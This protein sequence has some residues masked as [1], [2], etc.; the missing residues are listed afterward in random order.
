MTLVVN[1]TNMQVFDYLRMDETIEDLLLRAQ[2][3]SAN[4]AKVWESH[5]KN[6]PDNSD[7]YLRMLE[8]ERASNFKVMSQDEYFMAER[9]F[10]VSKPLM[11][12]TEERF[13]EMLNVLPP[14]YWTTISGVEMFCMSEM[15]TSSYTTQYAKAGDKYYSKMVDVNDRTTWIHNFLFADTAKVVASKPIHAGMTIKVYQLPWAT[16]ADSSED[17]IIVGVGDGDPTRCDLIAS[18]GEGLCAKIPEGDWAFC[19]NGMVFALADFIT[20]ERILELVNEVAEY[21]ADWLD[22]ESED[23]EAGRV[24][25]PVAESIAAIESYGIPLSEPSI[26]LLRN[27]LRHVLDVNNQWD[28]DT[29]ALIEF[30]VETLVETVQGFTKEEAQAVVACYMEGF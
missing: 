1:L 23:V 15:Y 4:S 25:V 16:K 27:A 30:L 8:N 28:T 20:H 21:C 17:F 13:N 3:A 26:I 14:L 10:Y 9:Q 2:D 24:N 18:D 6:Y 7:Y 29:D 22:P 12:V 19:F 5:C 11:A